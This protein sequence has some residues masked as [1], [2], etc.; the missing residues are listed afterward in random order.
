MENKRSIKILPPHVVDKIAAG[1]VVERPSSVVKELIENSLDANST[2][3]EVQIKG[4]GLKLISVQD[5]GFG[6]KYDELPLAVSRHATSK[7]F[8]DKDLEEIYTFG[9]RGEALPSI[10]AISLLEISSISEDEEIGGKIVVEYGKI[11]SHIPCVIRKGTLV[12]VRDLFLNIPARLKFLKSRS[13]EQKRCEDIFY[14]LALA[15]LDVEFKLITEK[16]YILLPKTK[17]LI[18]RIQ[19]IWGEDITKNLIFINET[20]DQYEVKGFVSDTTLTYHTSEKIFIYVNNRFVQS[21]FILNAIRNAYKGKLLS[22]EYPYAVI[23]ISAPFKDID[24]NVHP[25]KLEVRFKD[26]SLIFSLI[27]RAISKEIDKKNLHVQTKE[28]IDFKN[29][30]KNNPATS[31]VKE[32]RKELHAPNFKKNIQNFDFKIL[33]LGQI[34]DSYLVFLLNDSFVILDQHAAHERILYN[35]YKKAGFTSL[36]L[37]LPIK[38]ELNEDEMDFFVNSLPYLKKIGFEF[39]VKN[40]FICV[41]KIPEI[42]SEVEVKEVLYKLIR[43]RIDSLDDFFKLMAC[44]RAIKAKESLSY[45]EGLKLIKMWLLT[46]DRDFC[47]HGRPVSYVISQNKLEEIFKRR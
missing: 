39:D 9:F 16:K 32:E 27:H 42:L 15:H 18:D 13:Y 8:D 10:G 37:N 17:E 35:N 1:E 40:N 12:K 11:T 24:V 7:I 6:I 25:S 26:E 23:F 31:L 45:E 41:K 20:K 28:L 14:K 29:D 2:S 33:Y 21:K 44:K 38:I 5:D 36:K 34:Y 46:P 22:K 3:I 47:P 4:G 30:L 19:Y 43:S